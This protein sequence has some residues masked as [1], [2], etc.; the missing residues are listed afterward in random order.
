MCDYIFNGLLTKTIST[1]NRPLSTELYLNIINNFMHR[2]S[3]EDFFF[4]K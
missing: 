2:T 1:K 3:L 4:F